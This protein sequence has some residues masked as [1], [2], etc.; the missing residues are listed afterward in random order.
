MKNKTVEYSLTINP[1]IDI[2]KRHKLEDWL[3]KQGYDV[4]GSGQMVD[5]SECD[6]SFEKVEKEK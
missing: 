1:A 5:G 2:K 3:R 4:I 6:I